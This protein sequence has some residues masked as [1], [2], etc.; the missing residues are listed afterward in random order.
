MFRQK[1]QQLVQ[2]TRRQHLP[3]AAGQAQRF[4]CRH[5]FESFDGALLR[6]IEAV[7]PGGGQHF[8]AGVHNRHIAGAPAE[9]AGE[10]LVYCLA[11]RTALDPQRGLVGHRKHRHD[12]SRRAKTALGTVVLDHGL[13]HGM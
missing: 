12:E 11:V 1:S 6:A 9:V 2:R 13:L 7:L 4:P 5:G 10:G 3:A 8:A